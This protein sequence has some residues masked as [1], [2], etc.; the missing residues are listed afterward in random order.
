MNEQQNIARKG[1]SAFRL[2]ALALSLGAVGTASATDYVWKSTVQSGAWSGY[3]N[4]QIATTDP[5]TGNEVLTDSTSGYPKETTDTARF[6]S[7][8]EVTCRNTKNEQVGTLTLNANVTFSGNGAGDYDFVVNSTAGSGEIILNGARIRANGTA[9]FKNPIRILGEGNLIRATKGTRLTLTGAFLGAGTVTITATGTDNET[10]VLLK[11]DTSAFTGTATISSGSKALRPHFHF[12]NAAAINNS[13]SSWTLNISGAGK[14]GYDMNSY[15]PLQVEN[16]TYYF[17]SLNG[18]FSECTTTA[19]QAKKGITLEIGNRDEDCAVSGNVVNIANNVIRWV[20]PSKT[21]TWTAS[22]TYDVEITKGGTVDFGT[23]GVPSNS[24]KFKDVG[25][26]VTMSSDETANETMVSRFAEVEST[27]KAGFAASSA[28]SVNLYSAR[29][30]LAGKNIAKKGAGTI[31]FAGMAGTTYGDLTVE[32]GEL[33]IPYGAT[34]GAITVSEGATLKLDLTSAPAGTVLSYSSLSGNITVVNQEDGT[35]LNNSTR[36]WTLERESKTY[37]WNGA[38][39]AAWETASNWNYTSA[40]VPEATVATS[41]PTTADTVQFNADANVTITPDTTVGNVEIAAGKTL[42]ITPRVIFTS[43][44]LGDGAKVKFNTTAYPIDAIDGTLTLMTILDENTSVASTGSIV[45]PAN[46]NVDVSSRVFTATRTTTTANSP[47]VWTGATDSYYSTSGNWKIGD[48]DVG[49]IPTENDYVTIPADATS[50]DITSGS[51][52][53]FVYLG[54]LTLA[55]SASLA[56]NFYLNTIDST[57]TDCILTLNTVGFKWASGSYSISSPVNVAG[58]V[59]NYSPNQSNGSGLILSGTLTGTGTIKSDDGRGYCLFSGDTSAFAG[60]YEIGTNA[61]NALRD[62]TQFQGTCNGSSS[63]SWKISNYNSQKYQFVGTSSIYYFGQLTSNAFGLKNASATARTDTTVEVGGKANTASTVSGT[64]A[65]DSN[66][67]RKVGATS[68]CE[69]TLTESK[70]T[71][72]VK[73]GTLTLKGTIKPAQTKM[74]GTSATLVVAKAIA[75]TEGFAV[76]APDATNFE[77]VRSEL[78]SETGTYTYTLKNTAN[79]WKAAADGSWSEPEN[80]TAGVVPTVDTAVTF[81]EGTYTVT[82]STVKTSDYLGDPCK[83]LTVNG[84]VTFAKNSWSYISVKTSPVSGRGKIT[85]SDSGLNIAF[86]GRLT[87][88]CD[89]A[90]VSPSG[91]SYFNG[92]NNSE[93]MFAGGFG[94]S[95]TVNFFRPAAIGGAMTIADGTKV[96]YSETSSTLALSGGATVAA[97]GSAMFCNGTITGSVGLLAGSSLTVKSA[98]AAA[99]LS[100]DTPLAGY[101]VTTSGV[102]DVTYTAEVDDSAVTTAQDIELAASTEEEAATQAQSYSVSLSAA[103]LSQ[104]LKTNYYKP[105]AYESAGTWYVRA[106]LDKEVV[107]VEFATDDDEGGEVVPVEFDGSTPTFTL[108]KNVR[109]GLYYGVGTVANPDDPVVTVTAEQQ[110]QSDGEEISVTPATVFAP[111]ESVKYYK[112]VVSDTAQVQ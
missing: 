81:P 100:V 14:A 92:W 59:T 9:T 64:L 90:T 20:A 46:Y 84:D 32:E 17:G 71:V 58:I 69:L 53:G 5:E 103:Q 25:G 87:V 42:T 39:A 111:G 102:G 67:F 30:V 105:E 91:D 79:A 2:A 40:S 47:F 97:G 95:D 34:F 35:T 76:S 6:D 106:V 107:A 104:G 13:S 109:K 43:L 101:K 4:W 23:T 89:I 57:S 12:S 48:I 51:G 7:A 83:S 63:A 70:G 88:N 44:T 38:S 68:T 110:A 1:A 66:I 3:A 80:W 21:L 56:G 62:S 26:Y 75:E 10:G 11:G 15:F 54:K 27:A 74:T 112:V 29:T 85:L 28:A 49:E 60:T 22:N 93:F 55:K 61:Y 77:V 50:T 18:Y 37:I 31:T 72:E 45:F 99:A 16:A 24:I 98:V 52:S 36:T 33:I 78:D 8:A 82:L 65:D 96:N 94:A 19:S 108:K 86:E 41:L 73:E